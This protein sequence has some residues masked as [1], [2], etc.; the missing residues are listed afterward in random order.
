MSQPTLALPTEPV[1]FACRCGKDIY[2]GPPDHRVGWLTALA[3]HWQESPNC[4]PGVW[5]NKEAE[6][7]PPADERE[8]VKS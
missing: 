7:K 4:R 3:T 2:S 8:K 5:R 6:D 1:I